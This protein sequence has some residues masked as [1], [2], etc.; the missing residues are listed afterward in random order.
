MQTAADQLAACRS[1][2]PRTRAR[3]TWPAPASRPSRRSSWPRPS[4]PGRAAQAEQTVVAGG[5]RQPAAHAG[6]PRRGHS[7][8]CKSVCPRRRCCCARSARTATRGCTPCAQVA[9]QLSHSS[10]PLVPE[11]V[12]I[13]GQNGRRRRRPPARPGAAGHA[14]QPAGRGEIGLPAGRTGGPGPLARDGRPALSRGDGG[15]DAAGRGDR[16]GRGGRHVGTARIA[17]RGSQSRRVAPRVR[18]SEPVVFSLWQTLYFV[19]CSSQSCCHS[20]GVGSLFRPTTVLT[21]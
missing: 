13:A 11:R 14:D 10:Q 5:G 18:R 8:C 19:R 17:F 15:H 6:R 16:A 2:S 4:W 12:F 21:G 9:E 20:K 3:P 7:A 1:R